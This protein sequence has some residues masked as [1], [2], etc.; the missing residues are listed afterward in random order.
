MSRV[1]A[2][3]ARAQSR[4]RANADVLYRHQGVFTHTQNGRQREYSCRFS[5]EDPVKANRDQ[6]AAAQAFAAGESVGFRDVRELQVHPDDP[7]PPEG[8]VLTTPASW[9]GGRLEV[10]S[11]S[12]DD[13]FTGQAVGFCI[14][15]R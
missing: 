13:D 2:I 8:A 7:R 15:R 11:W 6:I 10:R 14:L 1:D 5:V 12:Q 9:D 3:R 4:L